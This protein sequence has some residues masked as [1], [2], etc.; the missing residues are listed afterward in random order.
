MIHVVSFLPWLLL[1][2]VPVVDP[3]V[4]DDEGLAERV[5]KLETENVELRRRIGLLADEVQRVDLGDVVPP[6]GESEY[7]LGPAASKVYSKDQGIS[8]GGYGEALY[9]F[10]T[11]ERQRNEFDFLRAILYVGYKFDENWVLNTEIEFEH[12]STGESGSVS[13]E[14]ATIDYL[15]NDT[16]NARAGLVLVP[17]GFLNELHEPPTF[18]SATRPE[19]ESRIIPSTWRE[20]GVGVFG[21]VGGFDYRAYVVNGLDATGFSA[22]GLRGGRQKGSQAKAEDLAVV[23]RADYTDTPGVLVGGSVYHGNSG[24]RQAG[25]GDTATSIYELH[26]EVKYRGVWARALGAMAMVDDVSELNAANGFAGDESVGEELNGAYV[27]IGYDVLNLVDADSGASL[28]PFVRLETIDTQADVPSGF[29]SASGT[30]Y[31]VFGIGINYQPIDQIVI[32]LEYQ[33]FD[34]G[35]DRVNLVVGYVF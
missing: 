24:H 15:I 13:V 11:D 20:N 27:E 31:D 23:L 25:L 22:G 34:P 21:A 10:Y 7:G 18:L 8:I 9:R 14:F 19:T 28:S 30:D 17:M 35:D 33:D 12:A 2:P 1:W 5:E 3:G 32:K 26:G 16:V 4:A 6:L 29:A